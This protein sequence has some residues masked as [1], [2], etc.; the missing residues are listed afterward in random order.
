MQLRGE[1]DAWSAASLELTALPIAVFQYASNLGA[2]N[3]VLELLQRFPLFVQKRDADNALSNLLT[4]VVARDPQQLPAVTGDDNKPVVFCESPWTVNL[5]L[6]NSFW[7]TQRFVDDAEKKNLKGT[8]YWAAQV[9]TK[10]VS[11]GMPCLS[12]DAWWLDLV[13]V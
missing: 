8:E 5:Y 3:L 6:G 2:G 9:N 11:S 12:T 13:L 10:V 4:L 7:V 1:V